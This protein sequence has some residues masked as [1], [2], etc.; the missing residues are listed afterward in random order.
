MKTILLKNRS[1]KPIKLCKN[2]L[3]KITAYKNFA[4]YN[5]CSKRCFMIYTAYLNK[6]G[7]QN[8]KW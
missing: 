4:N 6:F 3:K 8:D 7:E 1:K 2:C 5:Y